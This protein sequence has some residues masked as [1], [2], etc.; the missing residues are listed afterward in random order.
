[1]I[2]RLFSFG[3]ITWLAILAL[4]GAMIWQFI[5]KNKSESKNLDTL[6][7]TTDKQQ[8]ALEQI[9]EI[10]VVH[11]KQFQQIAEHSNQV[12]ASIKELDA[13]VRGDSHTWRLMQVQNF[14]EMAMVQATL[15]NDSTSAI[16]LLAAADNS[17]KTIDNP[18]LIPVRKA[19]Q[20]DIATLASNPTSNISNI[21]L[22]LEGIAVAI[23][24]LP[25]KIRLHQESAADTQTTPSDTNKWEARAQSTWQEL[26]SLVRIQRHDEPITPYFSQNDT[27]LINE[28]LSLMLEQASFAAARHYSV[29][30]K[31][32]I[33]HAQDWVKQYYDLNDP[34]VLEVDKT[35]SMLAALPVATEANLH[36]KTV[37][38]W[39]NFVASTPAQRKQ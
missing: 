2:K 32:E 8:Q 17:L 20:A 30:Y 27:S 11:D 4:A 33:K 35:L 28:N 29:L 22:Q 15:L 5:D 18:N 14:L 24:N 13:I 1:M 38:A 36:L 31:Q 37:D 26:K 39:A 19:L 6:A 10:L 12:V 21:I 25:H 3:F 7:Q 16:N 9:S 23:P 34:K